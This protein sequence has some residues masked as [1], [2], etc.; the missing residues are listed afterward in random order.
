M[1][2]PE[3]AFARV[4]IDSNLPQLDREFEYRVPE[5]LRHE[6]AIGQEVT[7]PFG[8]AKTAT[9][10][11]VVA[12]LDSPEHLGELGE[13][14]SIVH[15]APILFEST[16]SLIK[17]LASRQAS[18]VAELLKSV[19]PTRAV[20]IDK[21]PQVIGCPST[22]EYAQ[23]YRK[24]TL[25]TPSA[26]AEHSMGAHAVAVAKSRLANHESVL[27]LAP[28]ER[29]LNQFVRAFK[30]ADLVPVT[31]TANQTRVEKYRAFIN[32]AG[33]SGSLII[34]TR[35][36]A[37]L[38][39]ANLGLVM[40]WDEG[41]SSYLDQSAPYLSTREVVLV[42]QQLEKFDLEF[43]GNSLSTDMQRLCE[44]GFLTVADV[45]AK[46]PAIA[47]SDDVSR[48]DSL[49]W[50]AIQQSLAANRPVLVQVASRGI[51]TSAF[52]K[53]CR[54]RVRCSHCNGPIWL[55]ERNKPSC[56]WCNAIQLQAACQ[57]CQSTVFVSGRAGATRT[58]AELGKAFPGAR[59]IESTGEHFVET[60]P[61]GKT[62]VVATP[63]AEPE[64]PGGYGAVVLLDAANLLSR[65]TLR[66]RE[67]AIRVWANAI[68]LVAVDGRVTLS[69]LAGPTAQDFCLWKI[70]ELISH[71]LAER[72]ELRFPP[73]VRMASVIG[74]ETLMHDLVEKL[75]RDARY[76]VLGP[77]PVRQH[78]QKVAEEWRLLVK[79][80]YS[81]TSELSTSLKAF[82]LEASIA[83]KA[84]NARSG[85]AMRPVRVRMDEVEVI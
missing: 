58:A 51:A 39:I 13:I 19:V 25:V 14:A 55:D 38:P 34:G 27:V 53:S 15:R 77:L 75:G 70:R 8:K 29:A 52:C 35:S 65:D 44:L 59:L 81:A 54:E 20:S 67:D 64:T 43:F 12:L 68:A 18:P 6:V 84:V 48:V 85:R 61:G 17:T 37:F 16:Y 41:D 83:N 56:R 78:R 36:A 79:Y 71:E 45:I 80:P 40:M 60:V 11:Y 46:R 49:A 28:D 10:G 66:A 26:N 47:T 69:G 2:N 62:I 24:S 72:S 22:S 50:K 31:Y 33:E 1:P 76:E 82:Q 32:A 30:K 57:I 73:A 5:H 23:G 74:S 7:V 3:K 4:V 9:T 42:R 21:R 63:G